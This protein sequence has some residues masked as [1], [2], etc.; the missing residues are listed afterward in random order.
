MGLG[1]R[2]LIPEKPEVK[3]LVP[4]S[5]YLPFDIDWTYVIEEYKSFIS[6]FFSLS[7]DEDILCFVHLTSEEYQAFLAVVR[8]GFSYHPKALQRVEGLRE[9]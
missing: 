4:L 2:K 7:M 9:R 5:L 1:G 8:S 6:L 3:N